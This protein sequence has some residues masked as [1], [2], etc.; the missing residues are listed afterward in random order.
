VIAGTAA[1]LGAA[2]FFLG[3]LLCLSGSLIRGA[4]AAR[5]G[6]FSAKRKKGS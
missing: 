1:G 3:F 6:L 5:E 4:V 2:F